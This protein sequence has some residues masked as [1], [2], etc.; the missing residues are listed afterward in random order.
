LVK[1]SN[2]K[3]LNDL[4]PEN[5]MTTM[6]IKKSTLNKVKRLA[7]ERETSASSIMRLAIVEYLQKQS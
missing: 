6:A 7:K 5:T 4:K 2:R 3:N 1:K